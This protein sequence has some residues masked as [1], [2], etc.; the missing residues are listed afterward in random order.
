MPTTEV[1][2]EFGFEAAHSLPQVPAGH[3]CHRVHGHSYRVRVEVA[4]PIDPRLGWVVDFADLQA[5]WNTIHAELDHR[6]LNEIPGLANPTCE[7]L[8]GWIWERMPGLSGLEV[9]ET[10]TTGCRLRS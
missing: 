8:A 6:L 7:A 10:P 1:F 2:C 5:R 4:G 9:R 3:P